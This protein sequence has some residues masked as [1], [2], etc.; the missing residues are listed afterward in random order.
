MNHLEENE[1]KDFMKTQ[2]L[3]DQHLNGPFRD[4]QLRQLAGKLIAGIQPAAVRQNSFIINEISP[5][6]M[7]TT[8][9]NLLASVINNLLAVIVSRNKNSCIRITA[10]PFRNVVLLH[11]KDQNRSVKETTINDFDELQP[12][13]AMVG[14]CITI[15][16]QSDRATTLA[17][18]I[19]DLAAVA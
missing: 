2:F 5:A 16:N 17:M 6:I 1:K 4:V 19:A 8:D 9:E 11:I 10:K 7:V 13:A 18:S 12:L 3:F 14:G 15:C